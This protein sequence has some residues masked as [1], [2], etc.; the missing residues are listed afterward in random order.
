[1]NNNDK[2]EKRNI[3]KIEK[4][5]FMFTASEMVEIT[6]ALAEQLRFKKERLDH[7]QRIE[8]KD[9][10]TLEIIEYFS[11]SISEIKSALEK[12]KK[13]EISR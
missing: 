11:K 12:L 13:I 10:E 5:V 7:Y 9:S 4:T 8:N 3:D 2:K 1:M 6:S